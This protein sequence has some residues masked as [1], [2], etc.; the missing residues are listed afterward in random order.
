MRYFS[1]PR[2]FNSIIDNKSS[3]ELFFF[4]SASL[5]STNLIAPAEIIFE[6]ISDLLDFNLI[7]WKSRYLRY[8]RKALPIFNWCCLHVIQLMI[9][10]AQSTQFYHVT[11]Q[12]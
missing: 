4:T 10:W 5:I 11:C 12:N 8:E 2:L 7:N 1:F 3:L 6:N 9:S